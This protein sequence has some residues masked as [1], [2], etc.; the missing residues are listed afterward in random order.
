MDERYKFALLDVRP[1]MDS[2]ENIWDRMK[3]A[4]WRW[5]YSNEVQEQPSTAQI[6]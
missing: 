6:H 5:R 3:V 2:W 4:W 1:A